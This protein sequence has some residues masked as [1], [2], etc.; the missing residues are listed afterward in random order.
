MKRF[1]KSGPYSEYVLSL[2]NNCREPY[3]FCASLNPPSPLFPVTLWRGPSVSPNCLGTIQNGIRITVFVATPNGGLFQV[4]PGRQIMCRGRHS[5]CQWTGGRRN[6]AESEPLLRG[7]G[8]IVTQFGLENKET[9][10]RVLLKATYCAIT[11]A[12]TV[13]PPLCRSSTQARKG[14]RSHD[15]HRPPL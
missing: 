7:T 13:V 5:G 6:L 1:L 9:Q 4:A 12:A 14:G 11:I 2:G 3:R 10:F 15:H 8:R